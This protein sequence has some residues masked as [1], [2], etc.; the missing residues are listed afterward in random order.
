ML[1]SFFLST[2]RKIIVFESRF[3]VIVITV[4]VVYRTLGLTT[5]GAVSKWDWI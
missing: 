5:L 3:L 2:F 4:L 1:K